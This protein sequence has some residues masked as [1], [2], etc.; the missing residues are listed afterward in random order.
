MAQNHNSPNGKPF[1]LSRIRQAMLS[2]GAH[3]NGN[4]VTSQHEPQTRPGT[5]KHPRTKH[6]QLQTLPTETPKEGKTKK[7]AGCTPLIVCRSSD[8]FLRMLGYFIGTPKS[9]KTSRHPTNGR[10]WV[11]LHWPGIT[12][13]LDIEISERPDRRGSQASTAVHITRVSGSIKPGGSSLLRIQE[14]A[15]RWIFLLSMRTGYLRTGVTNEGFDYSWT[16]TGS[17]R[18][19]GELKFEIKGKALDYMRRVAPNIQPGLLLSLPEPN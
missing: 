3:S 18:V 9:Y 16:K 6:R 1:D 5:Q 13:R 11:Q 10:S 8:Q 14:E 4:G 2:N 17:E 15:E 19:R 12:I 7:V